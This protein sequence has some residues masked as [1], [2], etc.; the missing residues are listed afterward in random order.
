MRVSGRRQRADAVPDASTIIDGR[1]LIDQLC[2]AVILVDP[3]SRIEAM[4]AP[5]IE[6]FALD[7]EQL[8]D[9]LDSLLP[10][11]V[12]Q[13]HREL[14]HQFHDGPVDRSGMNGEREVVGRRADGTLFPAQVSISK[15]RPPGHEELLVAVVRDLTEVRRLEHSHLQLES[16]VTSIIESTD[17]ELAVVNEHMMVMTANSPFRVQF[18][19]GADPTGMSLGE[20]AGRVTA[21]GMLDIL[22]VVRQAVD[23][24]AEVRMFTC[25]D[26]R[27]IDRWFDVTATPL[28]IQPGA[29]LRAR[30]VTD[31]VHSARLSHTDR[32]QDTVTGLLSRD[33][34]QEQLTSEL[35]QHPTGAVCIAMLD[36][37]QFSV[38]RQTLGFS[39]G[40]DLLRQVAMNLE[41]HVP[42][43]GHLG[44]MTGDTFCVAFRPDDV[45]DIDRVSS[46]L[47]DAVRQPV[48]VRGRNVRITA[49]VGTTITS[50]YED[51]EHALQESE[52]AMQ[53]ASRRGGNRCI[54]YAPAMGDAQDGVMRLW[55]ALRS[56]LQYR[57]MEVWFQPIVSLATDRPI[58]AEALCRWHHPQFGDVSPGEFIPIAERNSEIL[59]IGS[60]VHGRAAEVMN[61]LRANRTQRLGDF[62]MSVNASPNELAWPQFAQNLLARVRANDARPEWF[63][64]EVTEAALAQRDD[65]VR[66]N[67]RTLREA[68]VSI[69]LD[70]FGTGYSSLERIRNLPVDRVKIDRKFVATMLESQRTEQLIAAIVA[71]ADELG[72]MT[73]AEGVETAEQAARLRALGCHAAQGFLYAPAVPDSELVAVMRDLSLAGS[74][75]SW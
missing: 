53:E 70:D 41:R 31:L 27:G 72:I 18:L 26:S 2:D 24:H 75:P 55:N 7:P 69:S 13:R 37:D 10:T 61:M 63:A 25:D 54:P 29:I 8:P 74:R 65:A 56:A 68:G 40:D 46:D 9:T 43:G 38:V 16:L 32:V 62:Q 64:I 44:R 1:S 12:Q 51:L 35:L 71:L 67:I 58:A 19:A 14:V 28:R 60:F 15:W 11:A 57:Q 42:A 49:S 48:S 73:V 23:H 21:P 5:A 45:A 30:D 3:R 4:N 17:T 36:I 52:L 50:G 34:L 39:A 20:L 22:D 66:D 6:M 33:G 59:N 47:R